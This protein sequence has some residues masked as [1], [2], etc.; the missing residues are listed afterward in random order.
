M[1]VLVELLGRA[2]RAVSMASL[3]LWAALS[4]ARGQTL[5][6]YTLLVS[7]IAVAA[8]VVGIILFRDTVSGVIGDAS[9]CLNGNC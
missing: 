3:R 5:A 2:R 8:I 9:D 6:E 4:A 1:E 7:V